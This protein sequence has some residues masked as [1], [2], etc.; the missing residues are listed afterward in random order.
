MINKKIFSNYFLLFIIVSSSIYFLWSIKLLNDFPWRYVFTDWIINYKGGY[1]RRGLLGE[2]SINL[3]SLFNLNIKYIFFLLHFSIYLFFHILFYKYFK[4]FTKNYIFYFLCF[5]PLVFLY[6]LATFEAFARKEIFYIT[7]F[8]LSCFIALNLN[9]R[10]VIFLSTNFLVLL[11]YLIHESSIFFVNFFYLVFF[12][13]LKQN[14]YK[15]NYFEIF[16]IIAVYF[17]LFFLLFIPV[18]NEKVTYMVSYI[19]ENF[20]EITE[21]SGAISWLKRSASSSFLFLEVNTIHL[22][23]YLRYLILLHFV[24][25]FLFIL[26]KNNFFKINKYISLFTILTFLSPLCLFVLINDWGRLVYIYY[27]FS[28]I[29]TF[30]FFYNNQK[31]FLKIDEYKFLQNINYK[32]KI[33]LTFCYISLW[34]PKIFFYDKLDFFPLYDLVVNLAKYTI[35]YSEIIF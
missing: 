15:I 31:I 28:L 33:F 2:I 9:N 32:L 10:K 8:L 18:T 23:D 12:I 19:N 16:I 34:A 26:Q 30:Y 4:N 29:F 27:N 22:K 7:F 24:I 3:S 17:T 1:I 13:Y 25:I 20:F 21:F 11:S 6:P 14:N 5:S 35:K